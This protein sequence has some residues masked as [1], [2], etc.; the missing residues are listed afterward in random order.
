VLYWYETEYPAR[1]K[2]TGLAEADFQY[3]DTIHSGAETYRIGGHVDIVSSRVQILL[4][5][6]GF[7]GRRA[8]WADPPVEFGIVDV[9]A[10]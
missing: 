9:I 3:Y 2:A 4:V 10:E 6:G 7:T 1:F 5:K 8:Y